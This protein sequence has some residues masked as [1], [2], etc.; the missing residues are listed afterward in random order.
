MAH[1]E[2]LLGAW[3]GARR[4]SRVETRAMKHDVGKIT[5]SS[6]PIRPHDAVEPCVHRA[7]AEAWSD[8][9]AFTRRDSLVC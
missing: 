3:V 6:S 7:A 9:H 8:T 2:L 4:E 5:D 1:N